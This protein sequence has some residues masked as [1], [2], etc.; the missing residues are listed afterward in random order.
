MI[1]SYDT[2]TM[3]LIMNTMICPVNSHDIWG[4]AAVAP[5]AALS[6]NTRS[7]LPNTKFDPNPHLFL[8]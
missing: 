8:F 1:R 7:V 6:G 2:N 5:D 3:I 4:T